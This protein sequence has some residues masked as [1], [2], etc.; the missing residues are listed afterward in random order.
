MEKDNNSISIERAIEQHVA[1][2]SLE[3]P[4]HAARKDPKI[5]SISWMLGKRCNYDCSYCGE[6]WHDNY[7][8]HIKKEKF[9]NFLDQLEKHIL[10]TGKK[11]K[12]NITGGE[13]FVHP[14]FLEIL[15]YIKSKESLTQLVVCTN[16]S[17]PLRVYKESARY[18]TN[19]TV[20][21]H[22]E[23]SNKVIRDT[24]A[25][26]IE[27]NKMKDLFLNVNLMCLPKKFDLVKEVAQELKD[28]LVKHVLR[29]IIPLPSETIKASKGDKISITEKEKNFNE[30][31]RVFQE[32][33][34]ND[35]QQRQSN[36][37]TERELDFFEKNQ[38]DEQWKNI[39]IHMRNGFMEK[40]TDELQT[41]NLNSWT[42]WHCYVGIDSLYVQ[43]NGTVFRGDC[44]AGSEIGKLGGKI[45]WPVEPLICPLKWC[46]CNAVMPVRK[47]KEKQDKGLVND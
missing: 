26:I 13:P 5:I 46:H 35:L 32:Q 42:G 39:R 43:H 38:N 14:D 24:V 21:L 40:N 25:K 19:L 33:N 36:Y 10:L 23:Q 2:S 28:N 3:S 30:D 17:L 37:Y 29:K 6:P 45:N 8:P 15:K 22:L 1:V 44:L 9:F 20:S 27:L 11:F 18:V 12:I 16:G 47:Y 4:E 31:K 41:K 7:S 34:Q